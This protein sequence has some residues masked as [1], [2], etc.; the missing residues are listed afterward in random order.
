MQ[1]IFFTNGSKPYLDSRKNFVISREHIGKWLLMYLAFNIYTELPFDLGNGKVLP[2]YP[3]LLSMPL[4]FYMIRKSIKR[5]DLALTFKIGAILVASVLFSSGLEYWQYKLVGVLQTSVSVIAGVILFRLVTSTTHHTIEKVMLF[6]WIIL[7]AGST[8]EV[9]GPLIEVS[10]TFREWAYQS[11]GYGVYSNDKRDLN[12]VGWIRP[13]FFASEPSLLAIGFMV[14]VNGWFLLW[15]TRR[16][17]LVVMLSSCFAIFIIGSPV[18]YLSIFVTFNI[19]FCLIQW[20]RIVLS[21]RILLWIGIISAFII[22]CG[23]IIQSEIISKRFAIENFGEHV[24]GNTSENIRLYLPYMTAIAV[25][26]ASPF[27]GVGI[28]GKRAAVDIANLLDDPSLLVSNNVAAL[29]TYF[30]IVGTAMLLYILYNYMKRTGIRR[31]WLLFFLWFCLGQ[32]M[33]GFESPRFWGYLFLLAGVVFH[34]DKAMCQVQ[35]GKI[36]ALARCIN[37]G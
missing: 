28:S 36:I 6:S 10:D 2:G 13:K 37:Y 17:F 23:V 26:K 35:S 18:V 19:L 3:Y 12:L 24:G 14:F 16:R 9:A 20:Q 27:F 5:F 8:L 29:L 15:P 25:I 31:V 1:T 11:G 33:G 30:G 21:T 22:I 7:L 34:A 4:V 32:T